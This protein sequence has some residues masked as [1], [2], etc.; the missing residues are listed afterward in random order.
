M[1]VTLLTTLASQAGDMWR[2]STHISLGYRPFAIRPG[3]LLCVPSNSGVQIISHY[4][5]WLALRV[6]HFASIMWNW[7]SMYG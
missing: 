6:C 3:I 5:P 7:K 2:N 1:R 4:S